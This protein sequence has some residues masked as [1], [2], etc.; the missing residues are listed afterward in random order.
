MDIQ[1]KGVGKK[2][3]IRLAVT[4]TLLAAAGVGITIGLAKL[5]PAA[6]GVEMSTLLAGHGEARA[7]AARRARSRNPGPRGHHA[8]H[9]PDRRAGASGS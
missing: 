7:D 1:R 6:P 5:K 2:K 3:A 8:D 4:L 9:G